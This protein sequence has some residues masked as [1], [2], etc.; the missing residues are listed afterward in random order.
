MIK[1]IEF[2]EIDLGKRIQALRE[3]FGLSQEALAKHLGIT[4]QAI[5]QIEKGDRKVNSLEIIKLASFLSISV[6]DLLSSNKKQLNDPQHSHKISE[7]KFDAEKLQ[8]LLLY[9]LEKCGGK[10]NV[11]ETVLYKLLYFIDF[12]ATEFFGHPITGMP[13][14]RLQYGPV[15][16]KKEY[17]KVLQQMIKN[18]QLKIIFHEYHGLRQ[19]RYINLS[20]PDR[21]IF[22]KVEEEIINRN[23]LQLSDMGAAE[24]THY[25]HGDIP[26][27][28]TPENKIIDY[29]LAFLRE[30]PYSRFDHQVLQEEATSND[31]LKE[32][33]PISEEEAKYYKNL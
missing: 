2:T 32:L 33:G 22:S 21:K 31:I 9:I 30:L 1:K 23:L 20:E 29:N 26:W 14:V 3:S 25:V 7:I 4:R 8:N 12:E 11:G 6:E 27:K 18:N 15:P 24:I 17:E 13:Y 16:K 10:P 19:K 5:G 28:Q